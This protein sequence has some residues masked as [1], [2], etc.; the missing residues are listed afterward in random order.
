MTDLA[1]KKIAYFGFTGVI[2]SNGATKICAAFN[3]AVNNSYDGV[4]LCMSSLG[5]YIAD[6]VYLYNHLRSLPLEISVHNTGNISSI[7]VAVFVA[8]EKRYCSRHGLFMIHPSTIG[9]FPDGLPAEK[10]DSALKAAL[11]EEERTE[12][13]LRERTSLPED[14]LNARRF[15]DVH[16]R[17]AEALG[18]GLVHAVCDFSLPKG[19]EIVQI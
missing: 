6:G 11:A 5:G 1:G 4:Y 8:A 2:D 10:L 17:P 14:L 9:P 12:N 13:I 7:A 15:K 3:H 18:H 16:I 19:N